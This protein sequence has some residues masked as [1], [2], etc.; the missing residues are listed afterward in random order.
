MNRRYAVEISLFAYSSCSPPSSRNYV[1]IWLCCCQG[2]INIFLITSPKFLQTLTSVV[3]HGAG[4]V[5][6]ILPER[7]EEVRNLVKHTGDV[8]LGVATQCVVS[9]SLNEI[10]NV[11]MRLHRLAEGRQDGWRK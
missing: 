5:L 7:A 6:V 2:E 1:W 10:D 4:F 9:L 3:G 11:S 8:M